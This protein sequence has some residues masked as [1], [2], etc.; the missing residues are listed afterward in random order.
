MKKLDLTDRPKLDYAD[1]VNSSVNMTDIV[2][3]YSGVNPVH[4]RIPCPFHN[5]KDRNLALYPHGYKCYVCGA[6]GDPI[7]YTQRVLGLDF[8]GAVGRINRDFGLGLPMPGEGRVDPVLLR[9]AELRQDRRRLEALWGREREED[10][11]LVWDTFCLADRALR[12]APP[13]SDR[14]AIA[15][16]HIA[17]LEYLTNCIGGKSG[18]R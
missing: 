1:I 17:W 15:A 3:Q 9:E 6:K 11:E 10:E 8:M 2:K 12:E 4:N 13:D 18:D 16:K 7:G 5:G 14:Y